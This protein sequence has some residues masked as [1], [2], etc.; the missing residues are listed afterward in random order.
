MFGNSEEEEKDQDSAKLMDLYWNR[1]EL[2][3]AYADARNEHF[4]LK[5]RI[6]QEQGATARV[7]QKL[8]HIE[9]LLIDPESAYSVLVFYQLRGLALR[10]ENRLALFAEQLKQQREKKQHEDMMSNWNTG[11]D[12]DS[13]EFEEKLLII[14]NSM[15]QTADQVS[16]LQQQLASM[17]GIRKLF[18]GRPI[19]AEMKGLEQQVDFAQA[20]ENSILADLDSVGQREAPET[21]GLDSASKRSINLMIIAY[22]QELYLQF[23]AQEFATMVKEASNKSAGGIG[24][25]NRHECTQILGQI[26]KRIEIMEQ[27]TDDAATLRKRAKLIGDRA[28]F[29]KETDVVPV[30]G[31]VTAVFEF[32][33]DDRLR[34][35]EVS[36]LG[37]NYWGISKVLSR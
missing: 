32:G 36:I 22:A 18:K 5:D 6:K 30:S 35:F 12:Q 2:K 10:C 20:E 25:G 15:R 26:L 1:A 34:E 8:D 13:A 7:Q 17:G 23:S 16:T 31:S 11:L 29:S 21:R 37:E 4:R 28:V 33:D 9:D 24:Y 19:K 27:A 3:K 14:R